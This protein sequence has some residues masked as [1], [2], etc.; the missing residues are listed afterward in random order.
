[1]TN[2]I[3]AA[4]TVTLQAIPQEC[5]IAAAA[6]VGCF[7]SGTLEGLPLEVARSALTEISTVALEECDWKEL[8]GLVGAIALGY[9]PDIAKACAR[10]I[11]VLAR[12]MG[13]EARVV[14]AR[15]P[16]YWAATVMPRTSLPSGTIT[17][18][19]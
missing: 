9:R 11:T 19:R 10:A 8:E 6:W 7:V 5:G 18:P 12:N 2:N 13:L 1:M 15:R 3:I 17:S 14:R 4:V 16:A